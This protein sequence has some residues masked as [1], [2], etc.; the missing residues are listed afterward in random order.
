MY[1]G[2]RDV[3]LL[4]SLNRELMGNIVTQQCALYQFK[5]EETKVNIYG[6]AAGEK[7]YNGPFLF[8]VLINRQDEQFPED[9][10]GV[11][12]QQGIDYYFLRELF[13]LSVY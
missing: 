3:S 2:Q 10:E 4:R 5:L 6:E 11:Q 13:V 7:F 1:T 8:N 9:D 12:F